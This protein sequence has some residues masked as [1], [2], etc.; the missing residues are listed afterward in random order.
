MK[1]LETNGKTEK[2]KQQNRKVKEKSNGNFRAEKNTIS[3]FLN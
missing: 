1:T 2:S 3:K